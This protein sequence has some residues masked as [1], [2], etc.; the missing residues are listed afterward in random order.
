[1]IRYLLAYYIFSVIW[2]A[3]HMFFSYRK[4]RRSMTDSDKQLHKYFLTT[5]KEQFKKRGLYIV[6]LIVGVSAI[7]V[8]CPILFFFDAYRMIFRKKK[9]KQRDEAVHKPFYEPD[10]NEY[11]N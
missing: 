9:T 4:E 6:V 8:A 5:L 1:M 3:C 7:L 11:Q 2:Q 10:L